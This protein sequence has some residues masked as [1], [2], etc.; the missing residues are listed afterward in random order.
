MTANKKITYLKLMYPIFSLASIKSSATASDLI[1]DALEKM[2]Y[3]KLE[4]NSLVWFGF[5]P[6]RGYEAP[7]VFH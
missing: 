1:L 6:Y 5:S 7:N 2:G 3:Y 4:M